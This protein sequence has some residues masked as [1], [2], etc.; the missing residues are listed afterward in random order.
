[1]DFFDLFGN[2]KR[3]QAYKE[4]MSALQDL[5]GT[6]ND[7]VVAKTYLKEFRAETGPEAEQVL[8]FIRGWYARDATAA[9]KAISKAI[10]K[11][12]RME[13]FWI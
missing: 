6:R 7:I 13:P 11:F 1:V 12:K 3:R 4:Q 2:R 10:K 5:L 9:D 8:E